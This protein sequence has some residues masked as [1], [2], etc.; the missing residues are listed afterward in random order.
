[1]TTRL[2]AS[3]FATLGLDDWRFVSNALEAT[4]RLGDY[5]EAGAFAGRVAA[6][7]GAMDHH[8]AIDVRHPG[9]VHI[10][11]SSYDVNWVTERDVE[12]ARTISELAIGASVVSQ[13]RAA[14]TV[15]IGIDA[16]DIDAVRPFWEALLAYEDKP[17][18][19]EGDTV[20][21]IRDPRGIGPAVWFQEL[22]PDSPAASAD[23]GAPQRHK[24]HLDVLV[25]HDVAEDRVRQA[26]DA[27]GR[28]VSDA[29]AKAFW[30]L[31]DPEG[32]EACICTWQDRE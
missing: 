25:P 9:T 29:R 16:A 15:E 10:V 11:T 7:A 23:P 22:D 12:L 14:T 4:F 17:A 30:V 18:R 6:A 19:V 26:V 27:G 32:N 8:P 28:L 20:R 3:Q 13:P 2:P 24:T 31:A 1:M 21:A 5:T